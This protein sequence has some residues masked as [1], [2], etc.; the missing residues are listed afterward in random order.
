MG[1]PSEIG[2]DEQMESQ[3]DDLELKVNRNNLLLQNFQAYDFGVVTTA[4]VDQHVNG[5][6]KQR[7]SRELLQRRVA[8]LEVDKRS[9]D[10]VAVSQSKVIKPKMLG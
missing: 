10:A 6:C 7:N 1:P 3:L 8:Q 4:L 9:L 5:R 2:Q